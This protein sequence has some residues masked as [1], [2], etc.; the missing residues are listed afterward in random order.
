MAECSSTSAGEQGSVTDEPVAKITDPSPLLRTDPGEVI[1]ETA[2]EPQQ[3]VPLIADIFRSVFYERTPDAIPSASHAQE[4]TLSLV[5]EAFETR[6]QTLECM[7]AVQG[8]RITRL[9]REL[10]DVQAEL[11]ASRLECSEQRVAFRAHEDAVVAVL[12]DTLEDVRLDYAE[13]DA[14]WQSA[15]QELRRINQELEQQLQAA[16]RNSAEQITVL[17][18]SK[19]ALE[20]ELNQAQRQIQ[21]IVE[22]ITCATCQRAVRQILY[23]SLTRFLRI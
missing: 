22:T 2:S 5:T 4:R 17:Q 3:S 21:T 18:E 10:Q 14:S 12:Q 23:I 15:V 13:R 6:I 9:E 7:K 19:H 16:E 11:S 20:G 1:V 8:Q